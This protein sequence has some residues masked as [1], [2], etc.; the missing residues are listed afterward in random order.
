V[1]VTDER[2]LA[3]ISPVDDMRDSRGMALIPHNHDRHTAESGTNDRYLPDRFSALK[4]G[5][6][7]GEQ[8]EA[9]ARGGARGGRVRPI[10]RPAPRKARGKP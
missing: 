4:G 6:R 3:A 1:F 8:G 9:G 2:F 7:A 5:L 10:V